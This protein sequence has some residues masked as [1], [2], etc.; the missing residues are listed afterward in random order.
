M[1]V[2]TFIVAVLFT[3][4]PLS[5][6]TL[7]RLTLDE[8]IAK[9]TEI[10]RGRIVS[11]HYEKTGPIVYTVARVAVE[12]RWKGP[13]AEHVEV[14]IP[15]GV[16][17]RMR[18]TFAGAPKLVPETEYVLFLW[19]GRSGI[20][21]VIGLSQGVFHVTTGENGEVVVERSSADAVVLDA[22]G[23]QVKDPAVT[24]PIGDLRDRVQT[25][26]AK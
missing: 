17:G 20:T 16:H 7:Q 24:M 13:A 23:G 6:S 12:E 15:G 21:Q 22:A 5:A 1:R 11:S 10:V 18:Q 9:S 25:G 4:P 19:T 26:T 8:M 2:L 3:L 14:A